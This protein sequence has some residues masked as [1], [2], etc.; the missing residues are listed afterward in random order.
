MNCGCV[1]WYIFFFQAEDGIRDIGV[2]GVQTCALPICRR[3]DDTATLPRHPLLRSLARDVRE[4]QLRLPPHADEHHADAARPATLLG[5]LQADLRDDVLPGGS[6]GG[7]VTADGTVQVHA[8]HGPA[9]QVEVLRELLLRLFEDD[10]SLEPRDVL[11]MCPDVETFAPLVSATFGLGPELPHPGGALRVRLADR[12]LRRTN[13]LLD[14]VAALLD[15]AQ[16]RVTASQVLDLAATPGVRRRFGFTDDDL[17]RIRD[18]V[19]RSGVRWGI[20]V[21]TRRPFDLE[22]VVQNTWQAGL[23]RVLL[24]V[25]TSEDEPVHLDRALPLDDVDSSDIDLAGR[26]AELLDRLEDALTALTGE[27]PAGHWI[28]TLANALDS[29]TETDPADAWQ[30]AQARR[31]LA[32]GGGGGGGSDPAGHARGDA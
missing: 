28:D 30:P 18:W 2:T 10:P 26:L 32:E 31:G 9:R 29:L 14:T 19:A 3:E 23:D 20:D 7:A 13:P 5:R 4:L 8:C 24:G 22:S 11:V 6:A 21:S 25:T 17:E 16:S 12:S 27:H 1:A 15:L